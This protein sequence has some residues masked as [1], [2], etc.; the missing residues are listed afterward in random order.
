MELQEVFN[1][2]HT[3]L[4]HRESFEK[5]SKNFWLEERDGDAALNIQKKI[6]QAASTTK[7][8]FNNSKSNKCKN[9]KITI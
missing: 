2:K 6:N 5:S 4:K 3:L 9:T 1:E 7:V 8:V